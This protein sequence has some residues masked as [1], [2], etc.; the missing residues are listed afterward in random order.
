MHRPNATDRRPS[1]SIRPHLSRN[2]PDPPPCQKPINTLQA[3][4]RGA[5]GRNGDLGTDP[6]R[7]NNERFQG[8]DTRTR[9]ST[10]EPILS[11]M[12]ERND[13]NS[14]TPT[15]TAGAE[16]TTTKERSAT[17]SSRT[18]PGKDP[19]MDR[20]GQQPIG[21]A[22]G[23]HESIHGQDDRHQ[24]TNKAHDGTTDAQHITADKKHGSDPART[25]ADQDDRGE[26]R[27]EHRD[28]NKVGGDAA[29]TVA[30]KDPDAK[31]KDQTTQPK[32][33]TKH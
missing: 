9:C 20:E 18:N 16:H 21:K 24:V 23:A 12:A 13:P 26:V 33:G 31:A 15:N 3:M 10:N 1:C 2:I 11:A 27:M 14:K 4:M 32:A 29:R 30:G 7:N 17:G 25:V 19:E 8:T 28:D 5:W 22:H 6:W